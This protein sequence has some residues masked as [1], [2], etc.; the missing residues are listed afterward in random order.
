MQSV[1]AKLIY[2]IIYGKHV[3]DINL[4]GGAPFTKFSFFVFLISF[5][6]FIDRW[7]VLVATAVAA[8]AAAP[9][10]S[11][12]AIRRYN[13]VF[14]WQALRWNFDL[15]INSPVALSCKGK[16]TVLLAIDFMQ[17]ATELLRT[18]HSNKLSNVKHNNNGW[19]INHFCNLP[20]RAHTHTQAQC[21]PKVIPRRGRA[22]TRRT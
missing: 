21:M 16:K 14:S 12:A 3:C 9:Q 6:K 7:I 17:I 8:A 4:P 18:P 1:S 5:G 13:W 20:Q 19:S 11:P 22:G 10:F 15:K 2:V